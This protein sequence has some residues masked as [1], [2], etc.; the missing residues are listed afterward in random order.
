MT[1]VT[2]DT[3]VLASGLTR[4]GS[5]AA[6]IIRHWQDDALVLITSAHI[7]DEL[8]RA[9]AKPYFASN[10]SDVRAKALVQLVET[11][12]T[13]VE[14]SVEVAGVATHPEDDKVLAP[15]LSGEA[16]VLCTRD[17]QLLK[18]QAFQSVGILSPGQLLSR[19]AP[20]DGGGR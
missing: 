15:A 18:L 14:L 17:K 12:A 3:N 19:L 20:G 10:V 16:S 1:R 13:V 2:L 4:S 6:E 5:A 8:T 11:N 9:F 7:L